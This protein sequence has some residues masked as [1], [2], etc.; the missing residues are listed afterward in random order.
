MTTDKRF[1][2]G[3]LVLGVLGIGVG[4]GL[5]I[6]SFIVGLGTPQSAALSSTG[7]TITIVFSVTTAVLSGMA[8]RARRAPEQSS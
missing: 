1:M 3:V 7:T 4:V 6:A 2:T 5:I 8:T